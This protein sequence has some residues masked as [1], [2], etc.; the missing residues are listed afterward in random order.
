[1]Y[2]EWIVASTILLLL[3]LCYLAF[4]ISFTLTSEPVSVIHAGTKLFFSFN[5]NDVWM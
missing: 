1:M 5:L 4:A 2:D 3:D